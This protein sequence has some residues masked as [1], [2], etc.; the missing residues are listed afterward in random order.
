MASADGICFT[1]PKKSLHAERNPKYFG[2]DKGIKYYNF[3][4]DFYVGFHGMVISGTIRDSVYL[5][6]VLLNQ[7]STLTPSKIMTNTE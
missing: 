7:T 5:L 3:L 2:R 4:S 6:E 1:T